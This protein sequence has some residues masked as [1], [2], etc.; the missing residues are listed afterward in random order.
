VY[1]VISPC[2]PDPLKV[3][4]N[5]CDASDPTEIE[6]LWPRQHSRFVPTES[7]EGR[8]GRKSLFRCG[9]LPIS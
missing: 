8:R 5:S 1:S 4:F 7:H 2:T 6:P 9:V 3:L